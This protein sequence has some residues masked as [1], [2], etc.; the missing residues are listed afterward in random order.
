MS[1]YSHVKNSV[2]T[3]NDRHIGNE[4]LSVAR[5]Y[6]K[7][8][9]RENQ[10]FNLFTL[11]H[12]QTFIEQHCRPTNWYLLTGSSNHI[13]ASMI[14]PLLSNIAILPE[15]G[16]HIIPAASTDSYT[17]RN[18]GSISSPQTW[19]RPSLES[20]NQAS[21]IEIYTTYARSDERYFLRIS[22]QLSMLKRLG[23]HIACH[24]SEIVHSTTWKTNGLLSTANLILLLVS[25][26]F[27]NSNFCY[28]ELM[29]S[30]VQRQRTDK[31]RCYIIP[32][33]LHTL[34]SRVLEKTP[35]RMFDFL[36]TNGK[37]ISAWKDSHEAY[38][39]ITNYLLDKLQML[40]PY[41]T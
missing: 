40:E 14:H 10:P 38:A 24:E 19:E 41:M 22:E 11:P 7:G 28:S 15:A 1:W 4:L 30:A 12:L 34:P 26:A 39:N 6:L 3:S 29:C 9:P 5:R 8:L 16:T 32:I 20:T 21:P 27:L 13:N 37:A 31:K 18:R 36:P 35:F 25:S 33:I 2:N 23:W 17:Q